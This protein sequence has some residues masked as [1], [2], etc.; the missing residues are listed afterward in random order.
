MWWGLISGAEP[1]RLFLS[2]VHTAARA[3][4]NLVALV[5]KLDCGRDAMPELSDKAGREV[6]GLWPYFEHR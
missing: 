5:A 1:R 6:F 4:R 3:T 2:P